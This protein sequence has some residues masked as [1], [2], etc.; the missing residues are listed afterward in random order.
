MALYNNGYRLGNTPFKSGLGALSSIYN[1]GGSCFNH[2]MPT[3]IQRASSGLF[4]EYAGRPIG[5]LAPA[6]WM[7]PQK[8]GAMSM[9]T[10]GSG[11]MSAN[12]IPSR[13]MSID[14]TGFGDLEATAGLVVSMACAM[15]GSGSMTA[16]IVGLLNMS[17]D[18]TGTG[19]LDASMN[20]IASMAIDMLGQGDLDA[21]IAAYGNMAIDIVVTGT[22]LT[23]QS[24]TDGVWSALN[25]DFDVP[26]TKGY[27][28]N[29]A[30][31][32]GVDYT[33][34]G[35]A[36][37]ASATRTLTSGGTAPT[38]AEIVAAIEAAIIP[39]NIAKVNNVTVKGVGT[40]GDPW[41]PA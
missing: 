33:A 38:T 25:T 37:W 39:V 18:L 41:N 10:V 26:G 32:G 8:S 21:T 30:A 35:V 20:G 23:V 28:L 6:S 4:G 3:G 40:A 31:S 13:A 34:L 24:I 29:N 22:G 12:L 17:V 9:R 14:M 2:R 27:A 19:G 5:N 7:L 36:V 11:S 1:G 15:S 16:N